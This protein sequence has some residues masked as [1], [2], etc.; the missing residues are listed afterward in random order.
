MGMG[1]CR[2]W[3]PGPEFGAEESDCDQGRRRADVPRRDVRGDF[4]ILQEIDD[5]AEEAEDAA[6]G[7][8]SAGIEGA[9]AGFAFVFLFGGGVDER[10]DQSA[11]EHGGGG[12]E[13]KIGA[14]G[15]GE[16]AHAEDFDR[17]D[18]C[19]SH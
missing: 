8:E 6:G 1:S 9:R 7:D 19:D 16:R 10:A 11:D 17:D 14:G 15:E 5:D 3:R 18:E 13:R 2:C 4:G 12:A